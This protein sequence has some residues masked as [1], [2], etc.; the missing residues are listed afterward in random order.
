MFFAVE[1]G[2]ANSR[3][4]FC[5]SRRMILKEA[6]NSMRFFGGFVQPAKTA[7]N[8]FSLSLGNILGNIF[9][10]ADLSVIF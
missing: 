3:L 6:E 4:P 5:R 7:Q 1:L 10:I 9:F 2:F 8:E